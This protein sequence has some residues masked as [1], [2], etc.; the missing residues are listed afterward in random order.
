MSTAGI[1]SAARRSAGGELYDIYRK[2][3]GPHIG[4]LVASGNA[5]RKNRTLRRV[6]SEMFD[7]PVFTSRYGEEAARGAAIFAA[8]ARYG[9]SAGD[10][11]ARCVK[12]ETDGKG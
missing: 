10:I 4:K 1:C 5:I 12:Y 7:M 11:A 3:G 6:L 2:I 8:A 9:E